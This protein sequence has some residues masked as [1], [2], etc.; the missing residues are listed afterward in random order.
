MFGR[1]LWPALVIAFIA[2]LVVDRAT[3]RPSTPGAATG[4]NPTEDHFMTRIVQQHPT[5]AA[6][7][8]PRFVVAV[9]VSLLLTASVADAALTTS[10]CLVQKRKAWGNCRKCQVTEQVK[11]VKGKPAD[12]ATCNTTLQTALTKITAKAAK[13]VIPCRY[14]DNGDDTI[15]DFDTGLMWEKKIDEVLGFP[16]EPFN[17][18]SC[19]TRKFTWANAMD[20]FISEL[21][22]FT[23]VAQSQVGH[24]GHTDWRLPTVAELRSIVDT[25]VPGC[26]IDTPCIDPI[27]GPTVYNYWSSTTTAMFPTSAWLVEHGSGNPGIG[28]KTLPFSVRAVRTGL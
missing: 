2:D 18:P 12:L 27:F 28:L 10:A 7:F 5:L 22:G 19:W 9:L 20:E 3:L 14:R 23:D 21:N 4:P 6:G 13:A 17:L 15:T 24:A 25:T 1:I 16:C 11:Q 26:R 8:L